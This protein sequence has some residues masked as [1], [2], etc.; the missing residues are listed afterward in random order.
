MNDTDRWEK[1]STDRD[2]HP[3]PLR[4]SSGIMG[5]EA[6]TSLRDDEVTEPAVVTK[7]IFFSLWTQS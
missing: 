7:I 2:V 5:M 3:N 6:I 1:R 4:V